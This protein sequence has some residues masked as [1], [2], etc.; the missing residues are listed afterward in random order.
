M[1][2]CRSTSRP[3]TQARAA[4]EAGGED[5]RQA[6]A[7]LAWITGNWANALHAVGDLDASRQR[8]LDS[9]EAY[10]KAGNPALNYHRQ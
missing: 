6:W 3:P 9:A 2:A 10:K 1:P 5:A 4:A 8:Q 7:D